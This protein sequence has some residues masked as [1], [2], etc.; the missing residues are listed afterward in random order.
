MFS[1]DGL[2]LRLKLATQREKGWRAPSKTSQPLSRFNFFSNVTDV[3]TY[4]FYT[5]SMQ[6]A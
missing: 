3:T 2:I 5:I 4:A 6:K 1:D